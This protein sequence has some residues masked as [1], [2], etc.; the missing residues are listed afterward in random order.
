MATTM[1]LT[2]PYEISAAKEAR[3]RSKAVEE[4]S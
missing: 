4:I 2:R 1:T 3:E